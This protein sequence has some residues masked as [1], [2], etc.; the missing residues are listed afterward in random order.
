MSSNFMNKEDLESLSVEKQKGFWLSLFNWGEGFSMA[1]EGILLSIFSFYLATEWF[2]NGRSSIV[3]IVLATVFLIALLGLILVVIAMQQVAFSEF[4]SAIGTPTLKDDAIKFVL[5]LCLSI[6]I[7]WLDCEGSKRFLNKVHAYEPKI[8]DDY[9]SD[10]R[11]KENHNSR[12]K[13]NDEKAKAVNSITCFECESIRASYRAKVQA[14]KRQLRPNEYEAAWK[15]EENDKLR[16]SIKS[17]ESESD[18]KVS[19]AKAR[20]E[21]KKQKVS[22]T[23]EQRLFSLD[24]TTSKLKSNIDSSN[25][26]ELNRQVNRE[27]ENNKNSG[28]LSLIT[29]LFLIICRSGKVYIYRKAGKSYAAIGEFMKTFQAFLRLFDP[30]TLWIKVYDEKQK[31]NQSARVA[32]AINKVKDHKEVK[33]L[34]AP[35]AKDLIDDG[36]KDYDAGVL[37]D[38]KKLTAAFNTLEE[39]KFEKSGE[40]F[41]N[42]TQKPIIL[43][44]EISE[45]E[46][47]ENIIASHESLLFRVDESE[48][49]DVLNILESHKQILK[50]IKL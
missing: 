35:L 24:T 27:R 8:V 41:E 36:I 11:V 39:N 33:Y 31:V 40:I 37:Y 19:E 3:D 9:L 23:Y 48:R 20:V 49:Q 32:V 46:D 16:A 18:F 45:I 6:S 21:D 4:V 10:K 38:T 29:Q 42:V 44:N 47:I 28:G 7:Y 13:L 1:I 12:S 25:G 2:L 14:K 26:A 34:V 22:D 43:P 30:V 15:K 5:F 17:L 50:R